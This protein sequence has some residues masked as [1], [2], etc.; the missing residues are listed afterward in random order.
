MM[1]LIA[2]MQTFPSKLLSSLMLGHTISVSVP[3]CRP[4][5]GHIRRSKSQGRTGQDNL[6]MPEIK[7]LLRKPSSVLQ[8]FK[9]STVVLQL[10]SFM[11]EGPHFLPPLPNSK[12]Q[13]GSPQAV[14]RFTCWIRH[15][16]ALQCQLET[17]QHL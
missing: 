14:Y 8:R 2:P 3:T 5:Y 11:Q 10:K 7:V 6:N 9:N 12:I 16:H 17:S 15:Y 4:S 1:L 13:L